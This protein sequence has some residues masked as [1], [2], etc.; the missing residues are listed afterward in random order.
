MCH[1]HMVLGIMDGEFG[2]WVVCHSYMVLGI[3]MW[4]GGLLCNWPE[5]CSMSQYYVVWWYHYELGQYY[6]ACGNLM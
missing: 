2:W 4:H 1:S 6:M 3:L 5:V